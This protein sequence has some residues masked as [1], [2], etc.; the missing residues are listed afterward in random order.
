MDTHNFVLQKKIERQEIISSILQNNI[1]VLYMCCTHGK[2]SLF[3]GL[4][5]EFTLLIEES[6]EIGQ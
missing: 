4:M 2:I 6:Q 3:N 1:Y 5:L